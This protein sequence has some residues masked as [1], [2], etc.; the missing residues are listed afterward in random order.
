MIYAAIWL[1]YYC[2]D[3]HTYLYM[4]ICCTLVLVLAPGPVLHVYFHICTIRSPWIQ[5]RCQSCWAYCIRQSD[6]YVTVLLHQPSRDRSTRVYWLHPVLFV[7]EII[8]SNSCVSLYGWA[9]S[10]TCLSH[11]FITAAL[12]YHD[13]AYFLVIMLLYYSLHTYVVCFQET[14]LVLRRRVSIF[15]IKGF[16]ISIVLLTHSIL[17]FAPPGHK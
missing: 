1:G 16:L 10:Y 15:E 7:S 5:V 2:H 13:L 8:Y 4:L 3:I 12:I 17:F 11:Y 14:I 9:L 6:L